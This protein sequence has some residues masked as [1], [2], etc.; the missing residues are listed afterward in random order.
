MGNKRELKFN[1]VVKHLSVNCRECKYLVTGEKR[2]ER[3][4]EHRENIRDILDACK[5][6]TLEEVLKRLRRD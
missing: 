5:G 6:Y 4:L 3:C 1:I 2:C